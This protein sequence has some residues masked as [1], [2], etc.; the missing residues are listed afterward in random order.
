MKGNS[1]NK[2]SGVRVLGAAA[3]ALVASAGLVGVNTTAAR[4]AA[5]NTVVLHVPTVLPA[6]TP[7]PWQ[8]VVDGFEKANPQYNVKVVYLGA[9]GNYQTELA[10]ELQAGNGAD[11]FKVSPGQGQGDSVINLAK[12]GFLMDLAS[13][14]APKANPAGSLAVMGIKGK[15]YALG[16]GVTPGVVVANYSLLYCKVAVAN[17]KTFFGLAGGMVPNDQ[18]LAES[19]LQTVYKDKNW[20]ANRLA[21]KVSFAKDKNWATALNQIVQM[22]NAGCFQAG[23]EAGGFADA[24]DQNFFG[25]KVYAVFVPGTTAVPFGKYVPPLSGQNIQATFI[26][27][28]KAAD[29]MIPAS[30]N[31]AVAINAKT[32]ASAAAKAFVNYF[33]ST[34]GQAAYQAITGDTPM[35]GSDSRPQFAPIAGLL[36]AHKTFEAPLNTFTNSAVSDALGKGVQ[37]LL[38]GQATVAQILA[39]MDAAW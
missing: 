24:I 28:V 5:N 20:A 22:K 39:S 21:K 23:A 34:A 13:T 36:D 31:T 10:T 3:V 12:A 33:A 29:T 4:A 25:Q 9:T 11:V 16:T 30:V 2:K 27:A 8:A 6:G 1:M 37:G 18:L 17:G 35:N 32:K 15:T 26:P 19:V 14:K 38:T 7:S